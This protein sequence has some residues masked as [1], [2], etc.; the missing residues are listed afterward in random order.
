MKSK[1]LPFLILFIFNLGF[2]QEADSVAL[3]SEIQLDAYR[4]PAKLITSTKSVGIAGKNFLSQNASDRL[5]ESVNLLP[6]SKMEERSPG[7][8]RFSI[9][10]STLRAPFG[11]RNVKI[12]LD[13]FSLTDASGNTYLN[14]LDPEIIGEIEIYKG[15]EGGDFGNSTGGTALLKTKNI[16]EKNLGIL[17][18]SYQRYKGK[19]HYSEKLNNHF[20]TIYSSF[21]SSDS[22]RNQAALE[23]KFLFLKDQFTYAKNNEVKTI[24]FFS[25]LHYETPGG[26]TLDQLNENPRQSR[27]KTK[28]LRSAEDQNAGIYNK[29]IFAGVSHL[30]NFNENFSHFV[31]VQGNYNDFRNPFITNYEKRFE[32]N[33]SLRTHLNFEKKYKS[34]FYQ[35]RIGFE[36]GAAKGMIRNFDNNFG[37]PTNPQNFDDLRTKSGFLF[38]SQKAEFGNQ[39]FLDFSGSFHFNKYQWTRIFPNAENGSKKFQNEFLPNFGISYVFPKGI[40]LRAKFSKGNSTPTTEEIRSSV[41]EI[42]SDLLPEFGWNKEIGLRKQWGK[43]LFTEINLFDFRLKNAIV[44]RENEKGQEFFVNAGETVQKGLEFILET[45]KFKTNTPFLTGMKMYFSGNF[46]DFTF[47]NYQKN[48]I[49]FTGNQLTGVPSTSLQSLLNL[50]LFQLLKIDILHFYNSSTPLNDANS[51]IAKPSFVGNI[52]VAYPLKLNIFE[53]EIKLNIQNMYNTNYSL[54]YDINAF[55]NRYYNPA[56]KRN[57]MIGMNFRFP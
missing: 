12:Y 29:M 44:R 39:L 13:D 25:D 42:N 54:G 37:V 5:L 47:K 24:L 15:P 22:Y 31:A 28:T 57:F 41:Q 18:G 48:S 30:L 14:S 8:Y 6:G 21:E 3:I 7:S 11:V 27:P 40:S 38:L 55:G 53:G 46:F 35:T 36:G 20:F 9:R 23:R 50:E 32:N 4:K 2:A 1:F 33:M 51:V 49:D 56:A 45:K 10:G 34:S 43:F 52:S 19:L 26:L 17:G 16:G